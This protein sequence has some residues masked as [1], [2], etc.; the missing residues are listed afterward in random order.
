VL[1]LVGSDHGHETV[2]GII[3]IEA[4]LVGAG[5][6]ASPDAD[7]M[8]AVSSGTASLLYLHPDAEDRRASLHDFLSDQRWVG[9]VF[10]AGSLATIGQAPLHHLAFAISL[11]ADGSENR[12]GIPGHSLAAAPRW[13]KSDR[14]GCGQH[15]GL[16]TFEQSPVLLIDGPGFTP[17]GTRAG[18]VHVVDLAPSIMRHLGI[19]APGMD[20]RP[21]QQGP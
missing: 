11:A 12:Y 6:K 15:G 7:D 4:E 18:P 13:D 3:D 21:L 10:E 20:G 16:G 9:Q 14:L 19:A 17:G 5:L 1:L 2:S 8:V